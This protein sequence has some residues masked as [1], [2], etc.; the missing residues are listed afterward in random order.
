LTRKIEF[1][2]AE[3][4]TE[5]D[6]KTEPMVHVLPENERLRVGTGTNIACLGACAMSQN[7]P[8]ARQAAKK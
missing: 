1:L 4:L 5:K 2:Q 8:F 6:E 7:L 3:T